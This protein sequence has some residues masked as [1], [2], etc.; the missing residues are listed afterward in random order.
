MRR[1]DERA[2]LDAAQQALADAGM[3]ALI[4]VG[5]GRPFLDYV[6]D[7]LAN[8]GLTRICLVVAPDHE[9]LR[10]RYQD[11]LALERVTVS[12]AVQEEPRGTADALLAAERWTEGEP[13]VAL[14]SDNDYPAAALRAL[15]A[16]EMPGVIAFDRQGLLSTGQIPPER[17]AAYALLDLR[18]GRLV[19][20]VEKP[21]A[22]TLSAMGP[23]AR[24]SMNCWRFDT[25]V[26]GACRRVPVSPRGELELPQAV[27][28]ALREG[29]F[30]VAAVL[31]NE[32]VLDLSSRSDVGSVTRLLSGR[33]VRL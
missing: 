4:P 28:L 22:A 31:S 23:G 17:I 6:L 25:R 32:P 2:T 14:N 1:A 24:V 9:L 30:E 27:Q 11:E 20:I 19:R 29:L 33:D 18:D 13:F 21:D 5:L 16:L 10:R 7:T 12:F 3:K 8:A 26:F 15:A